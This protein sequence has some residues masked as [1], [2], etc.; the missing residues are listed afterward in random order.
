MAQVE[1]EPF[2]VW[3]Q[4]RRLLHFIAAAISLHSS[5]MARTC[6]TGQLLGLL[7]NCLGNQT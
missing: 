6:F 7:V 1:S 5:T 2:K 4:Q 3:Q